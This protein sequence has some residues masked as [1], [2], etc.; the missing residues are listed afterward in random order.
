MQ[1]QKQTPNATNEQQKGKRDVAIQIDLKDGT[2][3]EK[4]SAF[5]TVFF[6][7]FSLIRDGKQSVKCVQVGDGNIKQLK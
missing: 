7:P 4:L 3:L 5:T 1:E 6:G 2:E